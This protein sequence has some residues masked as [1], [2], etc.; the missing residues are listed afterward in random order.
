MPKTDARVS[1]KV[2]QINFVPHIHKVNH[3][4]D[5]KMH[6]SANAGRIIEDLMLK[7]CEDLA[8]TASGRTESRK[9]KIISQEDMLS[10]G[11]I[12]LGDVLCQL[13]VVN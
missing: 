4:I 9:K 10:A 12:V 11:S 6:M 5:P 1:K 8:G 7:V 2:K 3:R 13:R